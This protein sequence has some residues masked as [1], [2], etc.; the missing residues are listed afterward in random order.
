MASLLQLTS[1]FEPLLMM[2]NTDT[3]TG[4][5]LLGQRAQ[6]GGAS[7][8]RITVTNTLNNDPGVTHPSHISH[9]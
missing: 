1:V 8:Y 5:L 2:L 3:T 4:P 7:T 9:L 6:I